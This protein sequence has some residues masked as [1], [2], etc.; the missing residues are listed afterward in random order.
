MA[1][2]ILERLASEKPCGSKN[3]VLNETLKPIYHLVQRHMAE[4]EEAQSRGY[5]WAQ[6]NEVCRELWHDDPEAKKIVWWRKPMM[7][8]QCYHRV[9]SGNTPS[10]SNPAARKRETAKNYHIALTEE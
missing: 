4:I 8:A 2:T 1:M 10:R 9:K 7:I 3:R 6:I 5:S